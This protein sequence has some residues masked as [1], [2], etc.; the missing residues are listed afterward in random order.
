ML[1]TPN[2]R[3]EK[4]GGGGGKAQR[5]KGGGTVFP[6][7]RTSVASCKGGRGRRGRECWE[8][9]FVVVVFPHLEGSRPNETEKKKESNNRAREG[10]EFHDD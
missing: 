1:R 6:A 5:G 2:Y 7:S 4:G 9:W 3:E 8:E 10:G